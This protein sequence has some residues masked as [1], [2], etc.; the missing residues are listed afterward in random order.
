MQNIEKKFQNYEDNIIGITGL[1]EELI[2]TYMNF[3]YKS[4]KKDILLITSTLYEAN[5][6]Y[7]KLIKYN[8]N[9]FLFPMDEFLTSE[10]VA[11]SPELKASRLETLINLADNDKKRIVI[12]HLMGFLRFLPPKKIYEKSIIKLEK[13]SNVNK[14]EIVR[15]LYNVGYQKEVLVNKTGDIGNRG[16]VLDIF[17]INEKDP[18]RI[19]FFGDIIESIR[20]FD[21]DTQLSIKEI[22]KINI[23]PYSEYITENNRAEEEERKQKNLTKHFTDIANIG[24]YLNDPI[25]VYKDYNQIKNANYQLKEEIFNY[26]LMSGERKDEY[27]HDLNN[28]VFSKVIYLMSLENMLPHIKLDKAIHY[29]SKKIPE[30]NNQTQIFSFIETEISKKNTVII[31]LKDDKQIKKIVTFLNKKYIITSEE[32]IKDNMINLIKKDI[33]EGYIINNYVILSDANFFEKAFNKPVYKSNFK[34]GERI[35]DINRLKIGD[36]VVHSI[37][38]V[39]IYAGLETLEKNAIKKDYVKIQYKGEDKLY[40]PVEKIDLIYKYS[41]QEGVAP[42]IHKLGSVEWQKTKTLARNRIKNIAQ[43]LL[44]ISIKRQTEKGYAFLLD[45]EEQILFEQEF[46]Y[47]ETTDQIKTAEEIKKDMEN[48][49]PMDRLLCGDVGYGKTEVAFR[50]AFKAVKSGKQVAYLC[51]TT[52]LS[53]QQYKNAVDRFK[54]FP[55]N[56]E[57]LNRFVTAKKAKEIIS[58]LQTGIVDIII[59]TH[60]LLSKDVCYKDLGLLI[61]DEEQR[62]GVE[63]KEKIKE[64]KTSIDVLTLSATPIP[65]TLQL[66]LSGI[67]SLSLLETPPMNRFPVQTYVIEY[68]EYIVKDAIY[69]EL[70]RGGQI[71]FVHNKISNIISMVERLKKLVPDAKI[72]YAHGKMSKREIEDKMISFIKNDF[73]VLVCTTIIET[74]IDLSNV[75]TVIINDADQFGLSQLYQIRGRVGRS[76]KIAYAYLMYKKHKV[77]NEVSIKRLN[78]IKDFTELGSGYNIALKD[79]SIRGAGNILGGEQAGFIDSIGIDLYLK[80]LEEEIKKIKGEKINTEEVDEKPLLNVG[81][82]I[83]KEYIYDDDIKIEIHRKINEIDSYEKLTKTKEELKDRFGEVSENLIIYMHQELFEKKAPKVGIEDVIQ[84]ESLI[85]LIFNKETSQKM[86]INHLF[87]IA[88]EISKMFKVEHKYNKTRLILNLNKLDRH[89]IYILLELVEKL[90]K[91]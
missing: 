48:N 66:S 75:N 35:K 40:I 26:S 33:N 68:N 4:S 16:F 36:Y 80:F 78:A 56:V 77:L 59:G 53:S 71:F 29:E 89:W 43:K 6:L 38:G 3:L 60:R 18:I 13:N 54:N 32:D 55:F 11:T 82:A 12:T 47:E 90:S 83:E 46:I 21:L 42:K 84:T 73:N 20:Y 58:K 51:P 67:K 2:A 37:H 9:V 70:S 41:L 81:T 52:I 50:A 88:R 24:A 45:D 85:E 31:C 34:H 23:F 91:C 28:F 74:G 30:F 63:H 49:Y 65:R 1:T 61:I 72:T 62:F 69:K 64:Y 7:Q 39:G 44:N 25:I 86:A 19:E 22:E 76:G 15:K 14:E 5:K 8:S 27:M 10:A 17:P 57:L 87:L 79:L